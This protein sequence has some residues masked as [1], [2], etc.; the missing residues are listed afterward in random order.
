MEFALC[1]VWFL[2]PQ[3][4]FPLVVMRVVVTKVDVQCMLLFPPSFFIQKIQDVIFKAQNC[5]FLKKQWKH[6][7]TRES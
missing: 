5:A 2:Q 6:E 4:S 3:M 1:C 7:H